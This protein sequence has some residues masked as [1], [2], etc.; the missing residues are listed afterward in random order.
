[1]T[2]YV[3]QATLFVVSFAANRFSAL[4]GGGAGLIQFPMPI[5]IGLPF[6]VALTGQKPQRQMYFAAGQMLCGVYSGSR[7]TRATPS[8]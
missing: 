4:S 3:D 5:F 2:S 7:S 1:M 8:P 6:G